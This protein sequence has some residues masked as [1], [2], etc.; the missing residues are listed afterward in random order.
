MDNIDESTYRNKSTR[1]FQSP[2][3]RYARVDNIAS[4]KISPGGVTLCVTASVA[5]VANKIYQVPG[6]R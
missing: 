2:R 5:P 1:C 3:F 4:K 6:T